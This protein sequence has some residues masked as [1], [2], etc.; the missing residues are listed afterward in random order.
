MSLIFDSL[1]D[2]YRT[3]DLNGYSEYYK[4]LSNQDITPE[5]SLLSVHAF[6]TMGKWKE[7]RKSLR[8]LQNSGSP[9]FD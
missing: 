7:A 8:K 9:I 4:S 1:R 5:I 2:L 6:S 3:G